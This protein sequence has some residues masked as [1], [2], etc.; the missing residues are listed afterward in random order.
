L[1]TINLN[2]FQIFAET[3]AEQH[4]SA[5]AKSLSSNGFNPSR[6]EIND[7]LWGTIS[8]SGSEVAILD[9]PLIQRLRYIRQLGVVHWIYP[10]AIH[11][12]FEHTLGVL[13]QVQYLASAINTLGEQQGL[14]DLISQ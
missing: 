11:T 7:P 14:R 3:F 9:S 8:L 5:Y 4:I 13:R 6:K 12:R 1:A 10:G 2:D